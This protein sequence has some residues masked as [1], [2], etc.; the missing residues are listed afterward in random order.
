MRTTIRAAWLAVLLLAGTAFLWSQSQNIQITQ[1]PKIESV[2]DKMAVIAWSTNV[3]G[4]T[5]VKFG[6]DQNNLNRMAEAPWGGLTHRV[7]LRRLQ[8]GTTY[9]FHVES[10]QA[11]G[12]GTNVLSQVQSFTTQ[13]GNPQPQS[14]NNSQPWNY[15]LQ[16]SCSNQ[17]ATSFDVTW[18]TSRPGSS[19]V[20]YG[21]DPNNMTQFQLAPWGE[22]NHKVTIG[23]LK[24]GTTYYVQAQ[25]ESEQGNGAKEASKQLTCTTKSQ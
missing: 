9:Y 2:T 10:G 11:Q 21:T 25:T 18:S 6:T 13:G 16:A 14:S 15:D 1:G 22:T 3:P 12:T 4:S 20:N 17:T 8:P 23:N 19:R 7:T 24:P 5:V